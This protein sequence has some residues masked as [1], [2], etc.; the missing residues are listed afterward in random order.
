MTER[1]GT[2]A[3]DKTFDVLEALIEHRRLADIAAATGLPKGTVHRI[4]RVMVE[5]GLASPS[6]DGGYLAGPRMLALSGRVL[7]RLD[8]PARARPHLEALQ[9]RTGRTVHLALRSGD[10][11]VYALKIEGDKPYRLASRVGMGLRLHCTSIGKAILA[12]M[13]DGEITALARRA[14]LPSRTARTITEVPR[15]LRE[16]GLVR[17]RGWATDHEENEDGVCA[18]GAAVFDHTGEVV[19]G[20]SAATLAHEAASARDDEI[21][22]VVRATAERVSAALGAA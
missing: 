11:A 19:G 22:P 7:R 16:I 1:N 8:V 2:S 18:V 3:A 15:L 5:R 13:T 20:V 9:T 10:E 12:T 4:L 14:G 6:G 21:G 17:S